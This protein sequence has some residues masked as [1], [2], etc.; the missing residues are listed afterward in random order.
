MTALASYS[1]GTVTVS[2]G[3]TTVTGTGTIWSGV[4]ARPGDILQIGNFQTIIANV[5]DTDTLTIPPWG[6]GAQTDVA[7]TIWQW[8]PQ[9]VAGAQVAADVNKLVAALN[10]N[11]VPVIVPS[12][13]TEPDPSL[14]EED[15]YAIQPG[16]YKFWL[17]TGGL[18]VYQGIYKGLQ[19][20]G[21][22]DSGT[23]YTVG[24]V[25][26]LSGSSY[27]CVSDHTNH[28]PPNATYW[29]L[30]ASKGDIG[31]TGPTGSGYGGTSTTS[32]TIGTGSKAFTTQS[33]LAY[34]DGAR[35]RATATAGA[36]G[37]LEG[38]ATYSGTTLTITSDKSSGT[39]TG[40]AWNFNVVGEP[41]AGDLS[42]ANNLSDLADAA[43]ARGNLGLTESI[44]TATIGHLPGIA[45]NTAASTGEVGEV[46]SASGT[47][48]TLS[49]GVTAALGSVPFTAGDWDVTATVQFNTGGATSTTDYYVSL[50]ATSASVSAPYGT[51]RALHERIPAAADH[52]NGFTI[53]PTQ[54][55]LNATTTLYINAQAVYTGSA[56]TA[57]WSIRGRR[58]R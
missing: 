29:Q 49:S 50:S 40:T 47:S 48:G 42:S 22:W 23:A 11:G 51:S 10:T 25:A 36:T 9:R 2:A 30:L 21:A 4:N 38:V 33:G 34:T 14:G 28:T 43:T 32:L 46:I 52:S 7:Y 19:L 6:G 45:S 37:W 13:A 24:D 41:G 58:M 18:W 16:T 1:T 39:G 56:T 26:T 31:G 27:V 20:K 55:L 53:M 44:V 35:V 5:P 17:K 15:Q 3:G 12:G 8:F 57:T 54:A